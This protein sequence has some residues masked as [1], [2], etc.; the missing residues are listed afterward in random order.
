LVTLD[1]YL[2]ITARRRII[3]GAAI[4]F[5]IRRRAALGSEEA[6]IECWQIKK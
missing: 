3:S 5:E 4:L 2:P 6:A 1:Y